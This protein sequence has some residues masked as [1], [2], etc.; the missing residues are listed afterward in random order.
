MLEIED[1]THGCLYILLFYVRIPRTPINTYRR[2]EIPS[3]LIGWN[4]SKVG[5]LEIPIPSEN[6]LS[7]AISDYGVFVSS[8]VFYYSTVF[9]YVALL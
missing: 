5:N 3:C 6:R 2:I 8:L 7:Y 4:G 1:W 9:T